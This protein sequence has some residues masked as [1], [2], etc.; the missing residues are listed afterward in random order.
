[1]EPVAR[2]L[3]PLTH[4]TKFSGKPV[5]EH[6]ESVFRDIDRISS[7]IAQRNPKALSV[8]GFNV[9]DG[10]ALDARK[11]AFSFVCKTMG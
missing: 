4:F 9:P 2:M 10:I 6:L 7:K 1:M 3:L 8:V 5:R 11:N